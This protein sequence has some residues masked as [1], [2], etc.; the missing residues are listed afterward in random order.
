MENLKLDICPRCSQKSHTYKACSPPIY[1]C[2]ECHI[3]WG[4]CFGI[5][6][7]HGHNFK[8]N[9]CPMCSTEAT[10]YYTCIPA[11]WY[12]KMCDRHFQD[13]HMHNYKSRLAHG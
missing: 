6:M 2:Y 13:G 4:E 3:E 8:E 12:C 5:K 7:M 10:E 11:K 1:E 9:I